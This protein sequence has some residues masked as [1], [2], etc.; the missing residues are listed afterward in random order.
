MQSA[1]QNFEG[2]NNDKITNDIQSTLG[3]VIVGSKGSW[4]VNNEEWGRHFTKKVQIKFGKFATVT[5]P[6]TIKFKI[7]E[8]L[9]SPPPLQM[10]YREQLLQI[11]PKNVGALYH[12]LD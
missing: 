1:E 10:L 3:N 7:L 11:F 8:N 6:P 4:S 9:Q 2:C 12:C 5:L